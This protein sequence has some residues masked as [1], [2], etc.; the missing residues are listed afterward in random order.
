M[1]GEERSIYGMLGQTGQSGHMVY[2]GF[3]LTVTS[4]E[5][6]GPPAAI[7]PSRPQPIHFSR[8]AAG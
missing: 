5:T 4:H 1:K 7:I 2:A 3:I 6:P 8:P